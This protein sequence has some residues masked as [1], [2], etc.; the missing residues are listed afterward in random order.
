MTVGQTTGLSQ[1]YMTLGDATL[2]AFARCQMYPANLQANHLQ[3][4]RYSAQFM[5]SDW[6]T[7]TGIRLWEQKLYSFPLIQGVAT[8]GIPQNVTFITD[9]YIT[10]YYLNAPINLTPT[11]T[12]TSGSSS[13]AVFQ[14]NHGMAPGD[15]VEIIIPVAVGGVV[16]FGN[17]IVQTVSS[18]SYFTVLA[19]TLAT[20]NT[21]GGFVPSFTTTSGNSAV[22]VNLQNHGY[23]PNQTFSVQVTTTV[24][25]IQLQGPYT[26]SAII[27]ANEFTIQAPYNAGST[28]TVAENN[29][30]CQ[31]ANQNN[32]ANPI[33]FVI[34]PISRTD[35]ADQPD[36]KS[37]QR[38]TTYFFLRTI[39][40][41]MTFWPTPDQNGPYLAN[42]WTVTQIQDVA[43][44]NGVGVDIPFRF[45][46]AFAAGLAA[47]IAQ[48]FRPD[49]YQMLKM[50][51]EDSWEKASIQDTEDVPI[52]ISPSLVSY[53]R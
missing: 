11:F 32:N 33:D 37:M 7:R 1:G 20:S 5:L 36:K 24:G 13:V 52:F 49:L 53:Y 17:Y 48:K 39:N 26:I 19:S 22:L 28:Q 47:R 41:T 51:A 8:Y 43:L 31:I 38:P 46:D 27:S 4:A 9:G 21:T 6:A 29:N 15:F 2:E 34:W 35:Y 45:Y 18:P 50:D 16:L 23:S 25:G 44:S 10:T 40:P 12:T 3:Q 42:F 14:A 30:Q